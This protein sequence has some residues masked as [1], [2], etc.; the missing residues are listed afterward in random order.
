MPTQ[1]AGPPS[2]GNGQNET[3]ARESRNPPGGCRLDVGSPR[4]RSPASCAHVTDPIAY[5]PEIVARKKLAKESIEGNVRGLVL[6]AQRT[7]PQIIAPGN[8]RHVQAT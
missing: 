7:Q 5:N 2:A 8:A 6:F 4:E 1:R 3:A